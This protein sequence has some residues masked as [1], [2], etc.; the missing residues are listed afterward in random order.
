MSTRTLRAHFDGEQVCLDEPAQLEPGTR[1][2]ITV[3]PGRIL[4]NGD[5]DW[6]L[7]SLEGL[8]GAYGKDEPEYPTELIKELNPNYEGR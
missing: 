5:E 8:A 4:D 6:S 1:L 3:L 2:I 7:L